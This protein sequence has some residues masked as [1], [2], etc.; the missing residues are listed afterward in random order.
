M[1]KTKPLEDIQEAY[2]AGQ[3]DFGENYVQ[4]L[5]QKVEQMPR[6]VRWHMIGN[7]QSNKAAQMAKLVNDGYLVTLQTVDSLKLAQKL[8]RA[9]TKPMDVFIEVHTSQ[10]ETKSGCSVGEVVQL[11]NEIKE[12]KNLNFKGLMTIGDPSSHEKTVECFKIMQELQK[13]T[14]GLLSMGMSADWEVA[15]QHGANV[16]RIGSAIFGNRVY[17]KKE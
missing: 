8:D 16:V 17:P 9:L 12:L 10:E 13:Q 1:S 14:G 11:F 6:D 7:L 5:L 2:E 15:T 3:R 4:E